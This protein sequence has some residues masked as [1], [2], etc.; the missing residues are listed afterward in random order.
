MIATARIYV[1]KSPSRKTNDQLCPVRLC[2]THN[3]KRRYYSIKEKIKNDGWLFIKVEDVSKIMNKCPRGKYRDIKFEY[4]RIVDESK[5]LINDM[6]VFS[7]G[8]F[9][10]MFLNK[11]RSWDNIFSALIDHIQ[12]LKSEGRFGYASSFESTLRAIKEFHTKKKLTY[13]DT[14]KVEDRYDDYLSGKELGFVDI[15]YTWLK[16]FERWLYEDGKAKSTVGVYMRNIRVL[17]NLAIKKHKIK[18]EYPFLEYHPKTASGR[19]LALSV[20]QIRLIADYK[21]NDPVEIFY[22]DLFM[23]SFLANGMNL[24]DIARLKHSNLSDKTIRFVREKTKNK[25]QQDEIFIPISQQMQTIINR[26]SSKAVGHDA[27]LFPILKQESTDQK[28]YLDIKQFTKMLNKYLR[29]IAKAVGITE[30]VSSYTA[31]HSWATISKNSG[32]STEFIKEQLGHSNV[33]VT[34]NYLKS[35]EENTRKEHSEKIEDQIYSHG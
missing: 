16:K 8:K 27:Y 29:K 11:M 24:S 23:F 28:K 10:E 34:E 25:D 31:R 6:S 18:A 13:N 1:Q 14:V 19:K 9:E 3:R 7:F 35:F 12:G 21:T 20:Y 32:A 26:H 15:N 4:D 5:A 2:V 22:R 30:R 33:I 17:F